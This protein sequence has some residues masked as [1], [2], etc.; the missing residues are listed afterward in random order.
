LLAAARGTLSTHVKE[1]EAEPSGHRLGFIILHCGIQGIW[2]QIAWWAHD[3][4]YCAMLFHAN[5]DDPVVFKRLTRFH[6]ACVWE[7]RVVDH[8]RQAWIDCL[9]S[10]RPDPER[11]IGQVL[12][13]GWY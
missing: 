9:L 2:L 10:G 12:P 6:M 13:E 3:D 4:I 5:D 1:I 11:Y 8:E 7:L